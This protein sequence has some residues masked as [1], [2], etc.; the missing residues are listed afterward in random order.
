MFCTSCGK[1][2]PDNS[3][4][5]NNYGN[6]VTPTP[7]QQPVYQQQSVYQQQ[8]GYYANQTYNNKD[9]QDKA[10]KYLVIGII[11]I[12]MQVMAYIGNFASGKGLNLN[13]GI[14]SIIGFVFGFNLFLI[15]GII[16]II[17]YF[18]HKK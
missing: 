2:L 4:F 10:D 14:V 5:C 16:L 1:N 17:Q 13:G 15:V 9:D 7:A 11:L 18:K 6:P 8:Q 12:V 3:V